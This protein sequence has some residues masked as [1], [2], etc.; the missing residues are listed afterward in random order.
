MSDSVTRST[1]DVQVASRLL[2]RGWLAPAAVIVVELA[3]PDPF[4]TPEGCTVLDDRRYGGTRLV[5]LK[6]P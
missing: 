5:F 3:V 2:R 4:P 1:V 6:G